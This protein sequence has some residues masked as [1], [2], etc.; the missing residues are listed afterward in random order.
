MKKKQKDLNYNTLQN[1]INYEY[2][3]NKYFYLYE[4]PNTF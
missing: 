3:K 4:L 2:H 1:I